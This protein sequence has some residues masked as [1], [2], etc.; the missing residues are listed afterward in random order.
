MKKFL[1][2]AM[3]ALIVILA[4]A[5]V[6]VKEFE[7]DLSQYRHLASPRVT[8]IH[9]QAMLVVTAGGDPS[10]NAG[11]A[12]GLLYK[13]CH[14][15]KECVNDAAPRARWRESADAPRGTWTGRFALPLSAD[16]GGIPD[17][18]A[19]EGMRLS[20]EKWSYGETAEILHVGPYSKEGPTVEKLKVFIARNG[21]EIAG[22]HEEEYLRG[23]GMFLKGDPEDYMTIIRYPVKKKD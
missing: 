18:T 19:P 17:V 2:V 3:L 4:A 9:E 12:I 5:Y 20:V 7:R 11:R 1:V 10:Q 6:L 21:Y 16:V 22:E 15:M 13:A 14:K 8:D 23:P